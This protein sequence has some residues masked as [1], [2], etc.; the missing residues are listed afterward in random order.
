[1]EKVD[2]HITKLYE[3][4]A[5]VK[6]ENHE[7]NLKLTRIEGNVTS[8]NTLVTVMAKEVKDLSGVILSKIMPICE[9]S[10]FWVGRI[11][12]GVFWISVISVGGGFVGV[13]FA[14]VKEIVQ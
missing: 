7:L 10:Q 4:I 6:D 11:K 2:E 12:Q 8:I 5:H 9:D 13:I 1:M 14:V 3:A